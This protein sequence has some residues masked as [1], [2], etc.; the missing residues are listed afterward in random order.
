MENGV[1]LPPTRSFFPANRNSPVIP[2][3]VPHFSTS[4]GTMQEQKKRGKRTSVTVLIPLF[5]FSLTT[6]KLSLR[7]THGGK[8][9]PPWQ[10]PPSLS[11]TANPR[12]PSALSDNSAFNAV[13]KEFTVDLALT[14][15]LLSPSVRSCFY[16]LKNTCAVCFS[17]AL[18]L[19]MIRFRLTSPFLS[20]H[21][22]APWWNISPSVQDDPGCHLLPQLRNTQFWHSVAAQQGLSRKMPV[23]FTQAAFSIQAPITQREKNPCIQT[24]YDSP[25]ISP[26]VIC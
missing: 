20:G 9:S 2:S 16:L 5:P 1:Y 26:F 19:N 24:S 10:H 3:P 15:S 6:H 23:Y 21:P 8:E 13:L 11:T 18:S 4:V 14:A 17:G 22:P 7:L 12:H 25:T